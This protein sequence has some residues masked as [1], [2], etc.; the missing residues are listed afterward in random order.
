MAR[1]G[2]RRRGR[3]SGRDDDVRRVRAPAR[4]LRADVAVVGRGPAGCA[5]AIVLAAAGADVVIVERSGDEGIRVGETLPPEVRV[6]LERLGVWDRFCGARHAASPGIVVAWGGAEPHE[7]DFILNPYGAGWCVDRNRFDAML[8]DAAREAGAVVLPGRAVDA[9]RSA[10]TW[11]VAA[12]GE[13][14]SVRYV[15]DATGR[16]SSFGRLLGARRVVHDRLV[17][18]VSVTT[19]A[20][21]DRR[22]LVEA[23]EAGWWYSAR[24]PDDRLVVAFHTDPAPGL[25]LRWSDHLKGAPR[26]ATRAF[27]ASAGD[28]RVV[29]ANSHRTEPAAGDGWLAVGDAAAAHDPICGLGIHWALESG[30]AGAEAVLAGAIDGYRRDRH[31]HF[32][33]YLATRR[34]YYRAEARWP[35]APFWRRRRG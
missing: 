21:A 6:P 20:G 14:I 4:A 31:E 13:A 17:A 10:G 2:R 34:E 15:V 12:G 1:A 5:A 8:A 9:W 35:D 18:L 26:T 30:I 27:G 24:L 16:A 23:G 28:V 29:P 32:D 25:R 22:A 19:A 7:N 3:G 33:R 11:D